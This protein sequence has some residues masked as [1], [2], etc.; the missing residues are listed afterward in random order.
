MDACRFRLKFVRA[1]Y[2]TTICCLAPPIRLFLHSRPA[3]SNYLLESLVKKTVDVLHRLAEKSFMASLSAHTDV[4][5]RG[6][7]HSI[8]EYLQYQ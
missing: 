6:Q 3:E 5:E 1:K 4:V 8:S 7:G 2:Q